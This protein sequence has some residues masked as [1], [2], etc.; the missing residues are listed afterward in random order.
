MHVHHDAV[1]RVAM[2]D[3]D[4]ISGIRHNRVMEWPVPIVA[5]F[6]SRMRVRGDVVAGVDHGSS[7][8]RKNLAAI[9][10]IRRVLV[11]VA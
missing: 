5:R 7:R 1:L 10:R 4:A 6:L 11:G 9:A 2:V 8:G 3:D